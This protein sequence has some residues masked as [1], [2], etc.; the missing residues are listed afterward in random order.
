MEN[1]KSINSACFHSCLCLTKESEMNKLLA[2][3]L[4]AAI[5]VHSELCAGKLSKTEVLRKNTAKISL[6]RQTPYSN[7][8]PLEAMW[9]AVC[10]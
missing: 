2:L 1:L 9:L 8:A 10:S 7:L 3:S 4:L 5:A 6:P